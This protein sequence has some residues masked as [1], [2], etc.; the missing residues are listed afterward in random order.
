MEERIY[1][2]GSVNGTPSKSGTRTPPTYAYALQDV[3]K[4]AMEDTLARG[5]NV[6]ARS[7]M[8]VDANHQSLH[9]A[10]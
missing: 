4:A 9:L 1:Q 5:P 7:G 6:A 2:V 3:T 8:P 10:R